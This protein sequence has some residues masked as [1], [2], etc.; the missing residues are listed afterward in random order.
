MIFFIIEYFVQAINLNILDKDKD[1]DLFEFLGFDEKM[2]QQL[3]PE[4]NEDQPILGLGQL[5]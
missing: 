2:K 3:V 5:F 1:S 4:E